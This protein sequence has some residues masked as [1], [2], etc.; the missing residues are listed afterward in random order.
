MRGVFKT[1]E[2]VRQD[3]SLY[4]GKEPP[5]QE[6]H[7]CSFRLRKGRPVLTQL[8][9]ARPEPAVTSAL[10]VPSGSKG[11]EI[12]IFFLYLMLSMDSVIMYV[13]LGE[14]NIRVHFSILV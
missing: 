9:S 1:N 3:T 7:F 11:T 12:K 2:N 10:R 13:L 5:A 6:P 4:P 14:F 8:S